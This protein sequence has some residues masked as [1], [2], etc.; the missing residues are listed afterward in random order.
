M[1]MHLPDSDRKID[2]D[3]ESGRAGEK[4]YK[5]QQAANEFGERRD[6]SQPRRQAEVSD[7]LRSLMKASEDFVKAMGRHNHSQ[8]QAHDEES[9]WLQTI[10][11]AQDPS[12]K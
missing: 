10:E 5:N 2:A 4:S 1:P 3:R 7:H 9:E 8:G 6:I 12:R 11:V